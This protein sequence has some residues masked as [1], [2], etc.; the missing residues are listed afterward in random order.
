MIELGE[1]SQD[2]LALLL[3]S[4]KSD[5][6]R[7]HEAMEVKFK[8]RLAFVCDNKIEENLFNLADQGG[9]QSNTFDLLVKFSFEFEELMVFI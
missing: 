6:Q 1:T 5:A 4:P 9:N 7:L 3:Q 8:F 2:I